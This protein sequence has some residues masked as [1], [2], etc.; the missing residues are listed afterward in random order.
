MTTTIL[1]LGAVECGDELIVDGV[2][3]L[4]LRVTECCSTSFR[5]S[6][7]ECE[8]STQ[9]ERPTVAPVLE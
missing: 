2:V 7:A 5:V 3:Y 1:V 6:L 4:V 8:V 9:S